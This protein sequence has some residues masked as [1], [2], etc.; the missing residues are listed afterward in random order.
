MTAGKYTAASA[1]HLDPDIDQSCLPRRPGWRGALGQV[2]AALSHLENQGVGK[3]DLFIFWG[4]YRE[5]VRRA[6]RWALIGPTIHLIFGWLQVGRHYQIGSDG[7]HLLATDAWLADH[8]HV[9]PG[10]TDANAIYIAADI[11]TVTGFTARLP[12]WGVLKQGYQ[13]SMPGGNPSLWKTPEWLNPVLGGVGM[14]YHPKGR[15]SADGTLQCVGRG[16]EFV[17]HVRDDPRVGE[18]L[19]II[20]GASR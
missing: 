16:Q 20:L 9:R 14:T 5:A 17:A 19:T 4:C 6:G 7:S 10:W 3:G 11:V 12:G 13:L 1:C 15:W 2:G 18:W 8:P